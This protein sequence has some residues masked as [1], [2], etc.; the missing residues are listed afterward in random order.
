MYTRTTYQQFPALA[1]QNIPQL[2]LSTCTWLGLPQAGDRH[3][4]ACMYTC[5][6]TCTCM[7]TCTCIMIMNEPGHSTI[8]LWL[9][10]SRVWFNFMKL[11]FSLSS[12]ALASWPTLSHLLRIWDIDKEA[13]LANISPTTSQLH[14]ARRHHMQ[15]STYIT[16]VL[17]INEHEGPPSKLG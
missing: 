14:T 13:E 11:Q 8:W 4:C 3:T 12:C 1:F 10:C 16:I 9:Y 15:R 2:D 17:C 6:C 5:T 7:Y